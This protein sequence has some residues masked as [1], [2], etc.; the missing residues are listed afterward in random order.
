MAIAHGPE[1]RNILQFDYSSGIA[2][3]GVRSQR[4]MFLLSNNYVLQ[5]GARLDVSASCHCHPCL[6]D[7]Q[8]G[9]SLIE[10]FDFIDILAQQVNEERKFFGMHEQEDLVKLW[11]ILST[12]Y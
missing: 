2:A 10:M 1:R 6:R 3:L 7:V 11:T 4:D 5:K 9:K 8:L 12:N